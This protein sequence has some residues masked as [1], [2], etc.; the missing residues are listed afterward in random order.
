MPI[1]VDLFH[2]LLLPL[3]LGA[4]LGSVEDKRRPGKRHLPQLR[5]LLALGKPLLFLFLFLS[6]S[7]LPGVLGDTAHLRSLVSR[8]VPFHAVHVAIAVGVL[9][10]RPP[11]KT[12][13]IFSQFQHLIAKHLRSAERVDDRVATLI[14]RL[15]DL[16]P[17]LN[18][19]PNL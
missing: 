1:H 14:S 5:N 6:R 9:H 8:I 19:P 11:I 12:L 13:D 7:L 18:V 10:S 2:R 17:R 15:A 16:L 3:P 4:H